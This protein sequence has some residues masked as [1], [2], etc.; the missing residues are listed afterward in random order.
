MPLGCCFLELARYKKRFASS[1]EFVGEFFL[2][3]LPK[4]GLEAGMRLLAERDLH[5][6]IHRFTGAVAPHKF[7]SERRQQI[8][9]TARRLLNLI[10]RWNRIFP[11][12]F[13]PRF[14]TRPRDS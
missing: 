8:L 2:R 14:A 13:F 1:A 10:D 6:A 12:R 11:E 3:Q 4:S 7:R 5:H 9:R